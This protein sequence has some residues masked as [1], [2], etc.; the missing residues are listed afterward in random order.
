MTEPVH[1]VQLL[2]EDLPTPTTV[3]HVELRRITM[4]PGVAPGRHRHAESVFGWIEAGAAVL[5]VEGRPPVV[6]RAGD[7]FHEPAGAVIRRFDALED[8]VA[9]V[10][11]FLLESGRSPELE[12]LD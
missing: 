5:E 11:A 9:F 8:G 3:A 7:A 6:L 4:A 2:D 12:M 1:R 10:G